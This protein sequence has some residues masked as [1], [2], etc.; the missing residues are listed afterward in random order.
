MPDLSALI[1]GA[2]SKKSYKPMTAKALARQLGV[3]DHSYREFRS[4][5]RSLIKEG[6]AQ[7]GKNDVIRPAVSLPLVTGTFKRLKAGDGVVR[8]ETQEGLPPQEYYVP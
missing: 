7:V 6:K 2:I 5:L 8:V 3:A 4:T 1:L